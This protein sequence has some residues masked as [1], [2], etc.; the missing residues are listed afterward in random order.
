[1]RMRLKSHKLRRIKALKFLFIRRAKD[2]KRA[3]L[4]QK[5]DVSKITEQIYLGGWISTKE[6]QQLKNLGITV[7]I[8]LQKESLDNFKDLDGFLWLPVEDGTPPELDQLLLGSR[9]IEAAIAEG[10]KVYIHCHGGIGRAPVLCAAYLIYKGMKAEEALK[11]VMTARPIAGPNL[12]QRQALEDFAN[13]IE[14]I[15]KNGKRE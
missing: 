12:A 10:K 7:N 11:T 13:L 3:A 6:W 9:F 4:R 15:E 1:M 8:S 5:M 14:L 2:I